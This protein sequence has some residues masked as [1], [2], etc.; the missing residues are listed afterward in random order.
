MRLLRNLKIQ[1]MNRP[2]Q[3]IEPTILL[4][5]KKC[6]ENIKAMSQKAKDKNLI[7]RPHFK[8]HQSKEIGEWIRTEGINAITVSSLNMALYFAEAGWR[9]ITVAFP[10][11]ALE[12]DKINKLAGQVQLNL[13]VVHEEN[14]ESICQQLRHPV[15]VFIKIDVGTNRTG[16]QPDDE[17]GI[18]K[19]NKVIMRSLLL[20][21]KG[22]LAHAGHTY[23]SR[24]KSEIQQ[25]HDACLPALQKLKAY[26]QAFFPNLI[27]SY[28]DTPSCNVVENYEGIDEIRPGN[29]VF[30]DLT[31][32]EIGSCE[33]EQIAVAL[34]C[35]IVA[36]HE[37]RM[38]IVTYGGGVHLSKD[39]LTLKNGTTIFGKP[40][41]LNEQGWELPEDE[42]YVKSLSQEHGVIK[43]S[44][45]LFDKVKVGDVIGILPVHSCMM[46]DLFDHYITLEGHKIEKV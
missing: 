10:L 29:F 27:I 12:I 22:F 38:E 37:A 6:L 24:S 13:L 16:L 46:V 2:L 7:F 45:G 41:L 42:S 19:I 25:I 33:M 35:P 18:E 8:T 39:R 4:D 23:G 1:F 9:D 14:L 20:E 28:G 11:N 5:K 34:A 32:V 44:E 3:I 26:Y 17:E 21:F 30:Y 15:G 40:V 43:A 36:K 31:Q